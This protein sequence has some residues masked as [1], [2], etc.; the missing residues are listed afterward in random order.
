MMYVRI[1]ERSSYK[2]QHTYE[3]FTI[4]VRTSTGEDRS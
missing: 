1:L 2:T 4:P 3:T